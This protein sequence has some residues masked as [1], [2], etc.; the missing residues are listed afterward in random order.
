MLPSP[1]IGFYIQLE[2]DEL[3]YQLT[4]FDL[5]STVD[6]ELTAED[7]SFQE[8]IQIKET[9]HSFD[10]LKDLFKQLESRVSPMKI[11]EIHL[12]FEN[13][14]KLSFFNG[15]LSVWFDSN[16]FLN[17][18]AVEVLNLCGF[19]GKAMFQKLTQRTNCY[20][21]ISIEDQDYFEPVTLAK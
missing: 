21:E 16:E 11:S 13:K 17:Q 3:I 10:S 7:S 12:T 14:Q 6:F 18:F 20:F 15:E 19:E 8:Y 2:S 4:C 9:N 5:F 1:E